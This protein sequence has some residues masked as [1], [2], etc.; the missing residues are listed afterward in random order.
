MTKR[1]VAYV[2]RHGWNL[3]LARWLLAAGFVFALSI[4]FWLGLGPPNSNWTSAWNLRDW[5]S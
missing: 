5:R 2:A 1:G 3:R 4:V